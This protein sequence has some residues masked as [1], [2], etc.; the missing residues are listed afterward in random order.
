MKAFIWIFSLLTVIS[1]SSMQQ[2]TDVK[3]LLEKKETRQEI[4]NTILNNPHLMAEFMQDMH[5][6]RYAMMMYYGNDTT[7]GKDAAWGKGQYPV[8]NQEQMLY[9]MKHNPGLLRT[10]MGNMISV[11]ATDSTFSRDMVNLMYH[12]NMMMNYM[13]HMY[14]QNGMMGPGNGMG[15]YNRNR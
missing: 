9:L 11:A 1:L 8:M 13:G 14:N 6:N 15:M 5:N 7:G 3:G 10:M 2:T 12:N 4:F